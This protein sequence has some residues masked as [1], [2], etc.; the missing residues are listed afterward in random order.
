MLRENLADPWQN[1]FDSCSGDRLARCRA[2]ASV[3]GRILVEAVRSGWIRGPRP[4]SGAAPWLWIALDRVQGLVIEARF[5]GWLA[6][7][8]EP[9]TILEAVEE[10]ASEVERREKAVYL[11]RYPYLPDALEEFLY[12]HV[13]HEATRWLLGQGPCVSEWDEVVL[14][15]ES[16]EQLRLFV[17]WRITEPVIEDADALRAGIESILQRIERDLEQTQ[18]ENQAAPR[19]SDSQAAA[20]AADDCKREE[21]VPARDELLKRA[22]QVILRESEDGT[23]LQRI[24]RTGNVLKSM[25]IADL[26]EGRSAW[27]KL[28][29]GACSAERDALKAVDESS[30]AS[31]DVASTEAWEEARKKVIAD[32]RSAG[33]APKIRANR[34]VSQ[35]FRNCVWRR[36]ADEIPLDPSELFGA[37]D[38]EGLRTAVF[39]VSIWSSDV[40]NLPREEGALQKR[41]SKAQSPRSDELRREML[42]EGRQG[43][44]RRKRS[45]VT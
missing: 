3:V 2:A 5:P 33:F 42:E 10:I 36:L 24:D 12:R 16:G 34:K 7:F 17:E 23:E 18:A 8:P 32:G 38:R 26:G 9:R 44:K 21:L 35:R 37:E 22:S 20:S 27:A 43:R 39:R 31:A 29:A 41:S 1:M 28:I 15:L 4:K 14:R 25:P 6:S 40:P 45:G 13:A 30:A 11:L 19:V